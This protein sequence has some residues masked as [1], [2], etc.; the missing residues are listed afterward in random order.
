M[1]STVPQSWTCVVCRR[2][3]T[4]EYF[5]V[6]GTKIVCPQ[7]KAGIEGAPKGPLPLAVAR[8][9]A[10]GFGAAIV[11]SLAWAAMLMS[12][13]QIGFV[14]IGVGWAVGVA[15]QKGGGR[16]SGPIF[17]VLAMTLTVLS[18]VGSTV[19]FLVQALS[20]NG[21]SI[22]DL[23]PITLLWYFGVVPFKAYANQITNDPLTLLFVGIA[24]YEAWRRNKERSVVFTGP[25][26]A[27]GA[28]DFSAR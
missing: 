24:L 10:F 4:D 3:I 17:Q 16:H 2:S 5:L 15:V 9:G 27:G 13:F 22:A 8:A 11:A 26:R 6:A 14:A 7:C 25:L 23:G 18:L 1:S 19:P 12:G 28:I 20:A 21:K